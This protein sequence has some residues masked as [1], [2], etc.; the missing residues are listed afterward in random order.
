MNPLKLITFAACISALPGCAKDNPIYGSWSG[1]ANYQNDYTAVIGKLPD[2]KKNRS[3]MP[4]KGSRSVKLNIS[5]NE[6]KIAFDLELDC[7]YKPDKNIIIIPSWRND[8]SVY[9]SGLMV[10]ELSDSKLELRNE[11]TR[12][13]RE[14]LLEYEGIKFEMNGIDLYSL[15]KDK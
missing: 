3:S 12:T 10:T 4:V 7:I 9:D 5:K 6:C 11:Y 14:S 2:P 1:K 15:N 13:S 8:E